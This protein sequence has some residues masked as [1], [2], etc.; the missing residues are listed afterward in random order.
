L[1]EIV[2]EGEGEGEG[3]LFPAAIALVADNGAISIGDPQNGQPTLQVDVD[4]LF[5]CLAAAEQKGGKGEERIG[6]YKKMSVFALIAKLDRCR[7]GMFDLARGST[8]CKSAVQTSL[9]DPALASLA[10][11]VINAGGPL[12]SGHKNMQFGRL[13][14]DFCKASSP[15]FSFCSL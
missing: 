7:G 14:F 4:S 10:C 5:F 6:N 12:S 9:A 15:Q 3:D 2:G 13:E 1:L 11:I 8:V